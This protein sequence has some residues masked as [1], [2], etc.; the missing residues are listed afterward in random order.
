MYN[1]DLFDE[2]GIPYP[3]SAYGDSY[4]DWDGNE[5]EWNTETLREVAMILSVDAN[6]NDA[7]MGE[8]DTNNIVQF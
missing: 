8:F 2:A 7:T 4:V 5:R 3:P 6:G 1:I